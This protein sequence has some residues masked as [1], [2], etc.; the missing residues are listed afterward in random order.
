VQAKKKRVFLK[1]F[2][3]LCGWVRLTDAR[4]PLKKKVLAQLDWL[5]YVS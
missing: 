1:A 5:F 4:C 3:E 2:S